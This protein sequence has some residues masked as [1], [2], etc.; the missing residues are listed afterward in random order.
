M[1]TLAT[2]LDSHSKTGTLFSLA[3]VLRGIVNLVSIIQ[4]RIFGGAGS[5]VIRHF[6]MQALAISEGFMSAKNA[7]I[8]IRALQS[9]HTA[10]QGP[11]KLSSSPTKKERAVR[12]IE[13]AKKSVAAVQFLALAIVFS[14]R[15]AAGGVAKFLML[16]V[17]AGWCRAF[18][19]VSSAVIELIGCLSAGK[20]ITFVQGRHA[21]MVTFQAVLACLALTQFGVT[22]MLLNT[23]FD[24]ISDT[25]DYLTKI[26]VVATT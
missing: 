4:I 8:G 21:A 1:T 19:G 25:Y 22:R 7:G 10:L 2:A 15:V 17:F 6:K 14:A 13:M 23:V 24:L 26:K 11:E 18:T 20:S 5:E 9:I 12:I 16:K 3:A